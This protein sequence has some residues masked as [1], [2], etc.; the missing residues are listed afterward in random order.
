MTLTSK[1]SLLFGLALS[2]LLLGFTSFA[3]AADDDTA[4]S[5]TATISQGLE[6]AGEGT[7]SSNLTLTTFIGNLIQ[8]L[9]TATG[10]LFLVLTVW[11]GITYMTAAGDDTKIKNAKGRIVSALIGL[12]IIVGA[13]ALT[14]YVIA[15]LTKASTAA[16]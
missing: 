3:L 8:A 10:I 16:S 15:A 9:L 2:M 12:I 11:A 7:Y 1:R 4:D 14:S 13:Y 6:S 5:A